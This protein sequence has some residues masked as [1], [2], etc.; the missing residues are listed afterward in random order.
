M[1]ALAEGFQLA[2]IELARRQEAER[3]E[4]FE[5]L[6]AGGARAAAVLGRAAD[7]GL[8]LASPHAVLV[9]ASPEGLRGSPTPL[10]G[11]IE[12]A[13]AGRYGDT[14]PLLSVHNNAV[15]C[16]FAAPDGTAVGLVG[17]RVAQVLGPSW[18]A[19]VGRPLAGAQSVRVSYEQAR[20][21][22]DVAA[23]LR[24]DAPV[25]DSTEL[26]V[27]RVLLR[28]TEA[29]G[30][31]IDTL[32]GP[33]AAARGGAGALLDTLA[34]YYATGGN[35]TETARR[36]HLSVRAVTYRL[37]RVEHLLGRD[38]T[39]PASRF[40]LHAAVLGARLLGWPDTPLR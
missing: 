7:L 10:L 18:R 23:R 38:P 39:E 22:L 14:A 19:A 4:V 26:A 11:R 16:V 28:D 21:M 13:L 31:L 12:R 30:E 17:D 3:R 27:Y 20:D 29:I 1:A 9:A 32:L 36:L 40:A 24:L 35:A 2:R 6:L 33:L 25:V 15:V 8:D 34:A 37:Q 5:A